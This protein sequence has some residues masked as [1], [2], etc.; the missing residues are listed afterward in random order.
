MPHE[1][2]ETFFR[3]AVM[4]AMY[5]GLNRMFASTGN[6]VG[7]TEMIAAALMYITSFVIPQQAHPSEY[8]VLNA[9][10]TQDQANIGW[11]ICER[12]AMRPRFEHWVDDIITSPFPTIK[13]AHG[14]QLWARSTQYDCKYIEGHKFR[15][16]NFDEIALGTE[17]SLA[18]LKM[19]VADV[20]GFVSGT[21]T[22]RGKNWYYRTE[23]R[24][25]EREIELAAAEGRTPTVELM[26]ASSYDNPYISHEYIREMEITMS[27]DAVAQ[28]IYGEFVDDA[29][30]LFKDEAIE[31]IRNPDLNDDM[32]RV[33][34]YVDGAPQNDID[35]VK[36]ERE[37][38]GYWI[39][40]W[41][42]AYSQDW[43][44]GMGIRVDCKPWR[45]LYFT[46]FQ[47]IPWP[48][49]ERRMDVQY[50]QSWLTTS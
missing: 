27:K 10:I 11:R 19:R 31:G 48:E 15:V 34:A 29:A 22:P 37:L 14:G 9:S 21:G 47:R 50:P 38:A 1:K 32:G 7:K 25:A 5:G 26:R 42:L 46:R 40:A 45:L 18:V 4:A 43:C 35:R 12:F 44:V 2:Q 36:A 23:W 28:K 3:R 17:E 33:I 20:G 49:V 8:P 16:I 41:D 24:P 13:L 30:K 6:R 39:N